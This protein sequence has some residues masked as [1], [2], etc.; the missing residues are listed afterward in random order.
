[1]SASSPCAAWR[2]A[3]PPCS[4][5]AG[6]RRVRHGGGE[7]RRHVLCGAGALRALCPYRKRDLPACSGWPPPPFTLAAIPGCP[8]FRSCRPSAQALYSVRWPACSAGHAHGG[9]LYKK[10]ENPYLRIVVGGCIVVLLS[11][12]V[13]SGDYNGAGMSVISA[14][15]AG[16]CRPLGLRS[17]DRIYGADAGC[18]F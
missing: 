18:R 11:L 6:R 3:F 1:M 7:H 2:A 4:V 9:T 10:I 14:A 12:L 5:L 16:R 13:R 17:E 15:L 8:P